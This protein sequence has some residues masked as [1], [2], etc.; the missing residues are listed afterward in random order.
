V[1]KQYFGQG[2]HQISFIYGAYLRSWPTQ[3]LPSPLH[4]HVLNPHTLK[5]FQNTHHQVTEERQH[6]C[7]HHGWGWR[8]SSP[9]LQVNNPTALGKCT[10]FS[11]HARCFGASL[12]SVLK[13]RAQVG[14]MPARNTWKL[15]NSNKNLH[16]T[17]E[18]TSS[19]YLLM[20]I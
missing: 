17:G 4:P 13:N 16:I 1:F 15:T 9:I 2:D 5:S 11:W 20:H 14:C 12:F 19:L 7:V 8:G 10:D 18:N 6:G 3:L